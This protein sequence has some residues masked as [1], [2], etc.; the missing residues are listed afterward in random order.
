MKITKTQLKEIIKEELL[1]LQEYGGTSR[2]LTT[3]G[4]VGQGFELEA[5]FVQD[6]YR[7]RE[8]IESGGYMLRGFIEPLRELADAMSEEMNQ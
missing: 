8:K 6:L 7:L 2:D 4:D 3:T 1:K 5:G